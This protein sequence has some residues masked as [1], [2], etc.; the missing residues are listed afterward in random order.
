MNAKLSRNKDI[1]GEKGIYNN[2]SQISSYFLCLCIF[3]LIV[4]VH[5]CRCVCLWAHIYQ[6]EKDAGYL[7]WSTLFFETGSPSEPKAH[8]F[9]LAHC[10]AFPNLS[11]S[12]PSL[13]GL[14]RRMELL[15]AS[16]QRSEGGEAPQ[17]P[18]TK[19]GLEFRLK[20]SMPKTRP[21]LKWIV[22]ILPFSPFP[23]CHHLCELPFPPKVQWRSQTRTKLTV[24]YILGPWTQT[25]VPVRVGPGTKKLP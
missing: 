1:Y 2:K 6:L 21:Q 19:S 9:G 3:I 12:V 10:L 20:V 4:Y 15:S 5:A 18:N 8:H 22:S 16:S 13:L 14:Q 25:P 24:V 7:L 23:L 11:V 17:T